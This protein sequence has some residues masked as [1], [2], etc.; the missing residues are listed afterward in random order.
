MN[1]PKEGTS[2]SKGNNR[3]TIHVESPEYFQGFRRSK[4]N[5]KIGT[6]NSE[7]IKRALI[8]GEKT[9][10][11]SIKLEKWKKDNWHLIK[12]NINGRHSKERRSLNLRR[13]K[14]ENMKSK[15][16]E[17]EKVTRVH[18]RTGGLH[19]TTGKR[20][21]K[22]ISKSGAL[23]VFIRN[24]NEKEEKDKEIDE[25]SDRRSYDMN[26]ALNGKSEYHVVNAKM[27][28]LSLKRREV[29]DGRT[30]CLMPPCVP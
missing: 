2:E 28:G 27:D 24:E 15:K 21:T 8:E 11:N 9:F 3:Q 29:I 26:P 20:G 4:V 5:R 7:R 17:I 16:S 1:A 14:K 18:G 22:L 6:R 23:N 13:Y 10:E 25:N 12:S 19:V 30:T